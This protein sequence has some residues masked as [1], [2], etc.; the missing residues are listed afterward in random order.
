MQKNFKTMILGFVLLFLG[1]VVVPIAT[2]I[3]VRGLEEHEVRFTMPTEAEV[4]AETG[5]EYNVF[6]ELVNAFGLTSPLV[7][8]TSKYV[9]ENINV[10]VKEYDSAVFL[11]WVKFG[12]ISCGTALGLLFGGSGLFCILLAYARLTHRDPMDIQSDRV[13]KAA[14]P[15]RRNKKK[16]ATAVINTDPSKKPR[17]FMGMRS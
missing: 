6:Q 13:I 17:H 7:E 9:P 8:E 1:L 10:L 12:Y 11:F 2:T 5:M 16:K 14:K 4:I 3:A 15:R